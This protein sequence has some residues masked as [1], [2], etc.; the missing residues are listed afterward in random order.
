MLLN[1]LIKAS[2]GFLF[3]F[4]ILFG[5]SCKKQRDWLDEKVNK[6]DIIPS[7]LDD[8]QSILDHQFMFQIYGFFSV[9]G[10]DNFYVSDADYFSEI[11]ER[12]RNC[13]IWAKELEIGSIADEW[14][15]N[16]RL[17]SR[18]NICLEGTDKI[19]PTAQTQGSR[20]RIRGT[21][22]FYRALGLYNLLQFFSKPY[23]ATTA[24]TDLG[25]PIR[26]TS[27][28]NDRQGRATVKQCYEQVI[29]DFQEA[30]LLLPSVFSLRFRPFKG[31]VKAMFAKL[32]LTL[33]DWTKASAYASE[34]L[35]MYNTLIDYNTLNPASTLP[36]PT[37]Q[38][39]NQ[40]VF[41]Y[42][43]GG[44]TG[45]MNGNK[46]IT[47]SNLYR[48]YHTN[49][50]RKTIFYRLYNGLPIFKGFYTGFATPFSGIATN[51]IYLIK[52]E[53]EARLGNTAS[54]MQ[55]LNTLLVKRWK[56]GTFVSYTA[57]TAEEALTKIITERRKE[58]PFTGNLGWEDLRRLNKDPRFART[59]R[60]TVA[61]QEYVLPPNDPRYTHAIPD[62]EILLT[63][64][65]QNI[66]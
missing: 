22:Y 57:A 40:E 32:Y 45:L 38:N 1:K 61:G 60:R 13:Y 6:S 66:R 27:D 29:K 30:E 50:L 37:L 47:D 8:Y 25:V 56:T 2:V 23:N 12:V 46:A 59:L 54:A 51:E 28:I 55:A 20:D 42:S 63:G 33:E 9:V 15:A 3:I 41:Y 58:L 39:N 21:A 35:T 5:S 64:I 53:A 62:I 24:A 34:A 43:E 11:T 4:F 48:S 18:A 17:I 16:Y 19:T 26:L 31:T 10:T 7:T 52:A 49:D 36:F 65:P 14:R 44:A